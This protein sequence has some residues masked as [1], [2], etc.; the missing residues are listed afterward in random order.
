MQRFLG[1]GPIRLILPV[2]L[3]LAIASRGLVFAIPGYREWVA[4]LSSPL[5]WLEQPLRWT[6]I[7]IAALMLMHGPAPGRWV[8]DI[9]LEAAPGRGLL[10][11]IAATTP[12]LL[13]PLFFRV[14]VNTS[15]SAQL[16]L[17]TALI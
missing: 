4:S 7:C 6:V 16:M 14:S 10:V 1:P 15:S 3:G 9:G 8:R 13:G 17:F 12:L 2:F 11:A 5:P